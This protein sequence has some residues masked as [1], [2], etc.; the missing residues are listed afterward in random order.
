MFKLFKNLT[1]FAEDSKI[2]EVTDEEAQRIEEEE[3]KKKEEE[4]KSKQQEK[5]KVTK[6]VNIL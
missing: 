6:I 3:K 4:S 2:C 1:Y 5:S